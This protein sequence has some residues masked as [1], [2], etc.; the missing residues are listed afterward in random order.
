MKTTHTPGPWSAESTVVWAYPEPGLVSQ[1]C[2]MQG[3]GRVY[4][5]EN[6][7]NADARLISAAPDLLA[8][9]VALNQALFEQ[10]NYSPSDNVVSANLAL[11]DAIRKAEGI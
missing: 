1:I 10:R 9:A 4:N 8:A 5:G 3:I 6:R 2:Q 11:R 7:L